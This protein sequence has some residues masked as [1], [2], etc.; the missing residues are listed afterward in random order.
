MKFS[1]IPLAGAFVVSVEA[2]TDERGLFART[3]CQREF[4]A[5]GLCVNFVQANTSFNVKRGTLRGLHFQADPN[6]EIKVVRCTRGR[7][8]DVL[9]DL[10]ETSSTF[11]QWFG[12][13]LNQDQRNALYVPAGF[14]HGFQTLTDDAEVLYL[15]SEYFF[16]DLAR[17]VNHADPALGIKWP[18]PVTLISERDRSLPNLS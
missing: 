14:A 11:R 10:R 16:A 7:I 6:P 15:M 4:A 18:L 3:F 17:G 2:T 8:F 13:E 12:L 9:V 1:P 5:H